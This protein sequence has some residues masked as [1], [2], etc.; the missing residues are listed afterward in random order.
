M[1]ATTI[2][3]TNDATE[4]AQFFV[5]TK[6]ENNWTIDDYTGGYTMH[7]R[8]D[9]GLMLAWFANAMCAQMDA[10]KETH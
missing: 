2:L 8:I 7:F 1:T 10:T 4:W 9:E 3:Q 5:R 6:M